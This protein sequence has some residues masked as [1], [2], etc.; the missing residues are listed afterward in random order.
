MS[1]PSGLPH[2]NLR[3][4]RF[5]QMVQISETSC[6]GLKSNSLK[7][8]TFKAP[9]LGPTRC[10]RKQ[11]S[12]EMMRSAR[13]GCTKRDLI[14]GKKPKPV[15]TQSTRNLQLTVSQSFTQR[16]L[17]S[18]FF[19]IHFHCSNIRKYQIS[20]ANKIQKQPLRVNTSYILLICPSFYLLIYTH[21]HF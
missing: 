2:L 13:K 20:K 12:M 5:K 9:I 4:P 3:Y 8:L 11:F 1:N 10:C 21:I 19:E 6:W 16:P 14:S 7:S 18:A 17:G 15:K